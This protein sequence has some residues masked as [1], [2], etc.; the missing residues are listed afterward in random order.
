MDFFTAKQKSPPHQSALIAMKVHCH[1][2]RLRWWAR[3]P[4]DVQTTAGTRQT[5][6]EAFFGIYAAYDGQPRSQAYR[7]LWHSGLPGLRCVHVCSYSRRHFLQTKAPSG[8][9]WAKSRL[10]PGKKGR[11]RRRK[12]DTGGR[13]MAQQPSLRTQQGWLERYSA[14]KQQAALAGREGL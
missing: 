8:P 9:F 13:C 10:Q 11:K 6:C 3:T 4:T 12:G 14:E 5:A 2:G 7:P 1:H